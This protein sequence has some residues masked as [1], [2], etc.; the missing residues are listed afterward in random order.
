MSTFTLRWRNRELVLGNRTAI[1][2]IVNVTPDSFSDGG[3]YL[4]VE[5]AVAQARRLVKDGADIIDIGG[6]ST[7]PYAADVPLE[8]EIER[9]LPVI[10]QLAVSIPVPISIDTTK[11]VVADAALEAGAAIINDIGALGNDSEMPAVAARHQVPV[12]IMHMQGTPRTMQDNP[13]YT[14]LIGEV[15]QFLKD[16]MARAIAA[17]VAGHRIIIDPGI[18][19]GKTA[20]HNMALIGNLSQLCDLGAPILVGPSR[21][22]FIRKFLSAEA[23]TDLSA[24]RPEVET[25]TQAAVAAAVMQ[26]AHIVRVHNVANTRA[27]VR[28]LDAIRHAA[29]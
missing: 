28:M 19:F 17:G 4:G 3:R 20:A 7:R 1:M 6:E 11:A 14:D 23:G 15:R 24:D 29:A 8:K 10:R 21:K 9:V 22:A 13:V 27:M 12:I 18:G 25:G 26:G 5:A 16:A 2:G